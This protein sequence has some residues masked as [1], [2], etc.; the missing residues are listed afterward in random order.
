MKVFL[1][2]IFI[3]AFLVSCEIVTTIDGPQTRERYKDFLSQYYKTD[4]KEDLFFSGRL[5]LKEHDF[6]SGLSANFYFVNKAFQNK[7]WLDLTRPHH[8][9]K[10]R[11]LLHVTDLQLFLSI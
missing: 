6:N 11:Q 10:N 2:N 8:R 5:R 4:Y 7:K 9:Y 1:I 3:L